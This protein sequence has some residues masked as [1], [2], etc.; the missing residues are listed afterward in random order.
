MVICA[1]QG[2]FQFR[3]RPQS[4]I[5]PGRR[6]ATWRDRVQPPSPRRWRAELLA[7]AGLDRWIQVAPPTPSPPLSLTAFLLDRGLDPKSTNKLGETALHR[8]AWEPNRQGA[9]PTLPTPKEEAT[10][11]VVR[12]LLERG[13][14][15]DA[16]GADV[17]AQDRQGYTPLH[18]VVDQVPYRHDYLELLL[19]AGANPH[20]ASAHGQTPLL[21]SATRRRHLDLPAQPAT[22][23]SPGPASSR[24]HGGA[25]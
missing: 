22:L 10:A 13:A 2:V 24:G 15:V 3:C 25:D 19:N 16:R 21:H 8:L 1:G 5:F 4:E 9:A 18:H 11:A 6:A 20:L 14:A 17:N 7:K 23:P 12:L